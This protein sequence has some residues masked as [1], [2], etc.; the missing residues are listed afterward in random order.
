MELMDSSLHDFYILVHKA[1]N[2]MDEDILGFIAHEILAALSYCNAMNV[3][4][5]DVKPKNVLLNRK[6]EVKLCDFGES[7]FLKG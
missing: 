5:L 4:H 3:I 7:R 1:Q 2:R 6:G